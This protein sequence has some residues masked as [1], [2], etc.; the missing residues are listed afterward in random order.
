MGDFNSKV[1]KDWEPWN[2]ILGKFGCVEIGL[3]LL[4]LIQSTLC[5]KTPISEAELIEKLRQQLLT[6]SGITGLARAFRIMDDD[7]NNSLE[8]EEFMTGLRDYEVEVSPDEANDMFPALDKNGSG[9]I[10]LNE[11]LESLK[12]PMSQSRI[13]ILDK[14]FEKFDKNDDG[15]V[16]VADLQELNNLRQHPK[17]NDGTWTEEEVFENFL[18]TFDST[19]DDPDGKITHEEFVNFYTGLQI[20]DDASFMQLIRNAWKI[21]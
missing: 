10:D 15:V 13:A 8:L 4:L 6:P 5:Q 16:T 21:Q 7:G 9:T 11:F 19:P 2:G 1:G 20:D 14:A 17:Y 12:P 3:V 18:T